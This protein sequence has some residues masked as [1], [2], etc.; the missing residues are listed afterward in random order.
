MKVAAAMT[1]SFVCFW[2]GHAVS[3]A[4]L[5]FDRTAFMYPVYNRLMCWSSDLED[6]AGIQFMWGAPNA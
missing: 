6:W 1:A 4:F 3:R 2:L 5:G